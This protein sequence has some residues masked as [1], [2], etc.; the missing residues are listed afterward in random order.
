MHRLRRPRRSPPTSRRRR[1]HDGSDGEWLSRYESSRILA[2]WYPFP[3][4]TGDVVNARSA[5]ASRTSVGY[6]RSDPAIPQSGPF[7]TQGFGHRSR[8]RWHDGRAL[9]QWGD[10]W[11][12][13]QGHRWVDEWGAVSEPLR[14]VGD[15]VEVPLPA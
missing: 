14:D 11:G 5:R 4:G 15:R 9:D 13:Q 8:M 2:A 10:Q 7:S 6:L 1:R 12:D 3:G